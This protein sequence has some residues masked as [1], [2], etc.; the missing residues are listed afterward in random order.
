MH[1]HYTHH[2]HALNYIGYQEFQGGG[3]DCSYI[4]SI[5]QRRVLL[6]LQLLQKLHA[7]V[8]PSPRELNLPVISKYAAWLLEC[9]VKNVFCKP[10]KGTLKL[11]VL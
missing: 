7:L 3:S 6:F 9:G 4:C 5:Q 11:I 8:H 2:T 1:A 10:A